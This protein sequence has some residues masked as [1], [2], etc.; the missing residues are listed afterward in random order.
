[1]RDRDANFSSNRSLFMGCTRNVLFRLSFKYK[2]V[3]YDNA[4]ISHA[5][6]SSALHLRTDAK[7]ATLVCGVHVRP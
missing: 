6:I 5:P 3:A 7:G 4:T 1:M 2:Y